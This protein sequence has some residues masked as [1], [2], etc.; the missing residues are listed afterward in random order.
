MKI[1]NDHKLSE[2]K[3]VHCNSEQLKEKYQKAHQHRTG[4]S[5]PGVITKD[6]YYHRVCDNDYIEDNI[7][8]IDEEDTFIV[9]FNC[10][11][12]TEV[13]KAQT[14]IPPTIP[15]SATTSNT[16]STITNVPPIQNTASL[17]D[18]I[19]E[20][21][22]QCVLQTWL[23]NSV[24]PLC[25]T[26]CV[27]DKTSTD[28]TY[29]NE[30]HLVSYQKRQYQ[31]TADGVS[32]PDKSQEIVSN[33]CSDHS[34][35][36]RIIDTKQTKTSS[37]DIKGKIEGRLPSSHQTSKVKVRTKGVEKGVENIPTGSSTATKGIAQ[38]HSN[39]VN[40]T[41]LQNTSINDKVSHF[42]S[43]NASPKLSK[44]NTEDQD[45][46]LCTE[47]LNNM[48]L[49]SKIIEGETEENVTGFNVSSQN[50]L[51]GNTT[52][53]VEN[54]LG[55][56]TLVT[57]NTETKQSLYETKDS[58][59]DV[60]KV[61]NVGTGKEVL[62]TLLKPPT[63]VQNGTLFNEQCQREN[64]VENSSLILQ[65]EQNIS[66]INQAEKQLINSECMHNETCSHNELCF[67]TKPHAVSLN[68]HNVQIQDNSQNRN[69]NLKSVMD[70]ECNSLPN[71]TLAET[72]DSTLCSN[73]HDVVKNNTVQITN[74]N[75]ANLVA[76]NFDTAAVATAGDDESSKSVVFT[77]T[78]FSSK[79]AD[80]KTRDAAPFLSSSIAHLGELK[81]I[82]KAKRQKSII[83]QEDFADEIT[84]INDSIQQCAP[85]G[86][87]RSKTHTDLENNSNYSK[88][89]KSK[90][91]AIIALSNI[92][93]SKADRS[94]VGDLP[95]NSKIPEE[96]TAAGTRHQLITDDNL[97]L[98]QVKELSEFKTVSC[99]INKQ[100]VKKPVVVDSD[101]KLTNQHLDTQKLIKSPVC[102]RKPH[103]EKQKSIKKQDCERKPHLDTQKS[104]K[105]QDCKGKP[106][107]DKQKSIKSQDCERKQPLDKQKSIKSQ[108]CERKPHLDTQ[109]SIKK[110]DCER[111]LHLDTK[112]SIKSQD[113]ERKQPL[114]TEKSIKKQDCER[115]P[116]LDTQ[117]LIKSQDCERKQHL[118]TPKSIK[119]QDC[120][121]KR[122]L[123]TLKPIKSQHSKSK[124]NTDKTVLQSAKISESVS[125]KQA[126]KC[127]EKVKNASQ[128]SECENSMRIY[129]KCDLNTSRSNT[130]S[131]LRT[132]SKDNTHSFVT[133]ASDRN[134]TCIKKSLS[135]CQDVKANLDNADKIF[136]K[137]DFMNTDKVKIVTKDGDN[138]EKISKRV[139][140]HLKHTDSIKA[141]NSSPVNVDS[142][143][144][145]HV[146]TSNSPKHCSKRTSTKAENLVSTGV[147]YAS[148]SRT[149]HVSDDYETKANHTIK[150]NENL[151]KNS[152]NISGISI[153]TVGN[154]M[155]GDII[156]NRKENS[157]I[158]RSD[159]KPRTKIIND[160][161]KSNT[162]S[163]K[164][165]SHSANRE[166]KTKINSL[167]KVESQPESKTNSSSKDSKSHR[168]KHH[169]SKSQSKSKS[170]EET[171]AIKSN[172]RHSHKHKLNDS[173]TA[174][175]IVKDKKSSGDIDSTIIT[176][177]KSHDIV[178]KCKDTD[179]FKS[180]V[181][182]LKNKSMFV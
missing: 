57:I 113:C 55:S 50:M 95:I 36:D 171:N 46:I 5:S 162:V 71:K 115:T 140:T 72:S 25:S 159:C 179:K 32:Q 102:E 85:D 59:V 105:S 169:S 40:D 68:N 64:I 51:I 96:I 66:Q 45:M 124:Q 125:N 114:D 48:L 135:N 100:S 160:S 153:A 82:T 8:D 104:V 157:T 175:T 108:D 28:N 127:F 147:K 116:H 141:T 142:D 117:K 137:T 4:I 15:C 146:K 144:I 180:E 14:E 165:L 52:P 21:D 19:F 84:I 41:R 181:C 81:I 61:T 182:Y 56:N 13:S 30:N 109:K 53:K 120:E 106:Y 101:E 79:P 23:Y 89:Q 35:L 93:D 110:Q 88:S 31:N 94:F 44:Q 173:K 131:K 99:K 87:S 119:K 118:D 49:Y 123:D 134:V 164:T 91:L 60:D 121:R 70:T 29:S 58:C 122:H 69:I 11:S 97:T 130:E 77:I 74:Q 3:T 152:K 143:N 92:V 78:G 80:M 167:P 63:L 136:S 42:S 145:S 39:N 107:L 163:S 37:Q 90:E 7:Y 38:P 27:S 155:S 112:K 75:I 10:P 86:Y 2:R 132:Q 98:D 9:D 178:I 12:K 129:N 16:G 73:Q 103:L 148:K 170:A 22:S 47:K 154:S 24:S 174:N 34:I 43:S 33:E 158:S 83:L 1:F 156:L 111:K 6:Q 18:K 139:D 176:Q 126:P 17:V 133:S 65:T 150:S 168:S 20:T 128:P 138:C 149:K 177:K 151:E 67:H 166:H 62:N 26:E 54:K 76:T 172:H 161:R